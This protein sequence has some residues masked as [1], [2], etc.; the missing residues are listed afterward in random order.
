MLSIA[1]SILSILYTQCIAIKFHVYFSNSDLTQNTVPLEELHRV[2][3]LKCY[4]L[5]AFA[6]VDAVHPDVLF[7]SQGIR[8]IQSNT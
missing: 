2:N 6:S 1:Y 7:N 8:N 5:C 3:T 4:L